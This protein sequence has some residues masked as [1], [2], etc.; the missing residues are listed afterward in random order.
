MSTI[1]L[2]TMLAATALAILAPMSA[3]AAPVSD[4]KEFSNNTATEYFVKDDASKYTSPYYRYSGGDWGWKHN[5]LLGSGFSSIKLEISAFDVDA[6][7]GEVDA[8]SVY[9]GS[10]WQFIGNLLGGNDIWAF[11]TFDLSGYSWAETQANAG[12]QVRMDIDT[13]QDGW[14]VT[15]GKSVLALDGGSQ[16]CVPTPGQPCTSTVPEPGSLAL[17]GLAIGGLALTKRRKIR[18]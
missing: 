1:T 18:N 7:Q 17:L 3:M 13:G 11:S 12:L 2:K 5:A 10:T 9:N 4:V 8:I 6:S 15:L 14:A 16:Q